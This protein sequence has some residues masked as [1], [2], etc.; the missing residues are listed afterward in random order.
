MLVI[1]EYAIAYAIPHIAYFSA[2]DGIFR[3]AYAKI[4]PHMQKFAFIRMYA[5]YFRTCDRIF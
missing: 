1:C 2:Y 5:A 4:M 3:I